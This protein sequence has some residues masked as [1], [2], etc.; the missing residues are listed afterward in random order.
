MTEK[1]T[2]QPSPKIVVDSD[3]KEQVALEKEQLRAA[4]PAP[5]GGSNADAS[6]PDDAPSDATRSDFTKS[7][8]AISDGA[9]TADREAADSGLNPNATSPK[10]SGTTPGASLPPASFQVLVSM[11]FTQA[12][13]AL[14]QMPSPSGEATKVDK[15][16]AKHTIDTLEMLQQK[17]KG[18]LSDEEA[19]MVQEALHALR[20]TYVSVRG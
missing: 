20:M 15:P 17:T 9:A 1:E 12:I 16:M 18:N 19:K 10:N 5:S 3:W 4:G 14:G 7:E 8:D 13:S 11:L 2:S 6:G